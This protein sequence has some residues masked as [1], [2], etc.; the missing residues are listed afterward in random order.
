MSELGGHDHDQEWKKNRKHLELMYA[1]FV[2]KTDPR[3]PA[4]IVF[5][6]GIERVIEKIGDTIVI[7]IVIVNAETAT[8]DFVVVV[9]IWKARNTH[10]DMK[11]VKEVLQELYVQEG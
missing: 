3:I 6:D 10:A 11:T 7:A 9:K 2:K 4:L 1:T 8:V 5:V